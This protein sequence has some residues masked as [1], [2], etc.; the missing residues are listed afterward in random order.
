MKHTGRQTTTKTLADLYR[1]LDHQR[2]VTITYRDADGTESIRTIE[3]TDIRTTKAG[4]IQIRALCRLRGE[5]RGFFIDQIHSYTCHRS[6]YVLDHTEA[7]T[8]A[9]RV[10][11]VRSTAQLIARELGRD[12]L[13]A[14]RL[15]TSQTTL[16][17]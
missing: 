5:A 16:A 7:T 10:I 4:R 9:G 3:I 8:P 2:A 15:T 14:R 17:A 6:T 13:P 11:V 12:Y 1:A